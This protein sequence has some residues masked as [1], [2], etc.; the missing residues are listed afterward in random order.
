MLK[1]K[2]FIGRICRSMETNNPANYSVSKVVRSKKNSIVGFEISVPTNSHAKKSEIVLKHD[3]S[4]QVD[5]SWI[6]GSDLI[7]TLLEKKINTL[8]HEMKIQRSIET[9]QK[10]KL[11]KSHINFR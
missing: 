7:I 2:E 8:R 5:G 10:V 4:F 9:K 11:Y 1:D 6:N 3:I